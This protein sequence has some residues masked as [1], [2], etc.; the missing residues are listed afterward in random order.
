MTKVIFLTLVTLVSLVSC[1]KDTKLSASDLEAL[2]ANLNADSEVEKARSCFSQH[3][4]IIASFQPSDLREIQATVES[5]GFY[6]STATI[7]ELEKCLAGSPFKEQFVQGEV[8]LREYEKAFK[9]VEKRFPELLQLS[10]RQRA[11][12][13][14]QIGDELPKAILSDHQ[15]KQK[16]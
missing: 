9:S 7:P 2:Q 5:C 11:A 16:K 1:S 12:M 3:C 15:A 8:F 4:R 6:A 10:P 13:I 14:V